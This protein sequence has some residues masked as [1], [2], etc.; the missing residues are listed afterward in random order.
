MILVSACLLGEN[1]RYDGENTLQPELKELLAGRD[2]RIICPELEGG[3]S[4]P[5]P[6]AEIFGGDGF[7][8]LRGRAE[9]VSEDGREI[10]DKFLIG[11]R[12]LVADIDLMNVE[13]AVLKSRSP[14]CGS[15]KIYSGVFEDRLREGSGVFAAFL[16]RAEIPVFSEERLKELKEFL[17]E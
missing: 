4:V 15:E 16:Q 13:C 2:I 6:P 12:N 8:V 1:C 7:D 11:I 10:T 14:S 3:F 9:V 17:E 5:R